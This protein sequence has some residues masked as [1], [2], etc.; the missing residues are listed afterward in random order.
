MFND[1]KLSP[2]YLLPQEV[3]VHNAFVLFH[4]GHVALTVLSPPHLK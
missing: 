1:G 2:Q 3:N 4:E